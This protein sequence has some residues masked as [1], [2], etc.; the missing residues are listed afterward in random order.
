MQ[1]KFTLHTINFQASNLLP[2]VDLEELQI[3]HIVGIVYAPAMDES[4]TPKNIQFQ[5]QSLIYGVNRM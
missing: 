5:N 4:A 2:P 1:W 3:D